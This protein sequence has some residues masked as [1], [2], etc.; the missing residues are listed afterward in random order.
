MSPVR[1]EAWLH[2]KTAW[3]TWTSRTSYARWLEV[4]KKGVPLGYC[5][6][7]GV[8]HF[9]CTVIVDTVS[10]PSVSA[11]AILIYITHH[12]FFRLIPSLNLFSQCS[13]RHRP[14]LGLRGGCISGEGLFLSL[15]IYSLS[16]GCWC[17][18]I[19]SIFKTRKRITV[20]YSMKK[21]VWLLV[22][23][24]AYTVLV[25]KNSVLLPTLYWHYSNAQST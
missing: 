21:N 13:T 8:K 16:A 4:S 22:I 14:Q 7:R 3:R 25:T 2:F 17:C 12:V 20:L 19:S 18:M 10:Q 1:L 23:F 15:C 5:N 24:G 11:Y 6:G 9:Y